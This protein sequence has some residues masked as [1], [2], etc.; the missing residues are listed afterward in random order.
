[1]ECDQKCVFN[2]TSGQ[3]NCVC[4]NSQYKLD[5]D[6]KCQILENFREKLA[7]CLPEDPQSLNTLEMPYL[8]LVGN[9]MCRF[10]YNYNATSKK[11]EDN[12]KN[13]FNDY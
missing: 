7:K 2:S 6:N 10:G 1:M 5:S 12:G 9:C 3:H 11:C 13:L 4:F 8:D